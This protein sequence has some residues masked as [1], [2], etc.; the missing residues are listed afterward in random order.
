MKILLLNQ[1][2]F[3][4]E[5][6]DAGHE[7]ITVGFNFASHLQHVVSTPLI[8]IDRVIEELPEGF[9]P[10]RIVVH[11]NSA[12]IFFGGLEETNIPTVFYSVD[13]HHHSALHRYLG[14]IFDYTF[15]A[16]KDFDRFFLDGGVQTEWMPLYAS[17]FVEASDTKEHGAVFVGTL[18]AKLNPERVRFFEELK[19]KTSV[20]TMTGEFWKIFPFSEIVINQ[21][22]KGDLNFR[23]FEAMMCGP[24]LLTERS[25]NGLLDLF[26][27]KKHLVTY[28]KGDVD[29]A[30]S[31]IQYYL[32]NPDQARSI[33][34][35]GRDE[36]LRAHL[37]K[38]RAQRMLEVL[39]GLSKKQSNIRNFSMAVNHICIGRS[40]RSVD[41]GSRLIGLTH[42]LKCIENGIALGEEMTDEIGCHLLLAVYDFEKTIGSGAGIALL[43]STY[44]R[45]PNMLVL[46][47]GLVREYLNRGATEKAKQIAQNMGTD[48][49]SAVYNQAETMLRQLV[50]ETN[51]QAHGTPN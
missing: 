13:T 35:A 32:S 17:R 9:V 26:E 4:E 6:R 8:H 18:N 44:E 7:V 12:P 21:T 15:I 11:D 22:V 45:Y 42:A 2:W 19:K 50:D 37:P 14:H 3:A 49:L 27:D 48:D 46:Q 29:E 47:L 24:M 5:F 20:F 33:G 51:S 31:L 16:Q 38:H 23:V 36:I 1:D 34:K 10:D 28:L 30:A 41:T 39:A 25:G 43:E 40:S